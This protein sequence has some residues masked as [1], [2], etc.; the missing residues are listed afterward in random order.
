MDGAHTPRC[1]ASGPRLARRLLLWVIREPGAE[2]ILGDIEEGYAAGRSR[3]WYWSQTFGSIFSWWQRSL[4]AGGVR[5]DLRLAV[6]KLR[7]RPGFSAVVVLTLALGIGASAAIFSV[8][9]GVLLSPLPYADPERLV[10]VRT[11]LT[12][13][14]TTPPSSPPELADMVRETRSLDSIGGAWYRPAALTDDASEPEDIDMAFVS[15]GFLPALAVDPL[16]GRH[17]LP[18]EDLGG[19]EPVIVLAEDLWRRRYG[20]DPDIVGKR[21]EMDDEPHTVVGVMPAGFRLHLPPDVGMPPELDAWVT[22][23]GRYDEYERTF[24]T[25]TVIGRLRAGKTLLD[26][27]AELV[28][29]RGADPAGGPDHRPSGRL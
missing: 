16:L 11:E 8:V 4:R 19:G 5:Q 25:F 18:Q 6:R 9:N 10:V 13:Q 27:N 15:A 21:I 26:A 1:G 22:F 2:A 7:L 20:A 23:G 17:P 24:R 28:A 14:G 3:V 29:K 12:S